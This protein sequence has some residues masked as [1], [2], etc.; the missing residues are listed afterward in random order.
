MIPSASK[1]K[2]KLIDDSTID[3]EKVAV[4]ATSTGTSLMIEKSKAKQLRIYLSL[5]NMPRLNN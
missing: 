1:K 2:K 5:S 4:A 3:E